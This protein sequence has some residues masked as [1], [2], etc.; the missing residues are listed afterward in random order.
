[1]VSRLA[2]CIEGFNNMILTTYQLGNQVEMKK[3]HP[4]KER[5]TLFLVVKIG[6]D[7]KIKCLGCGS[8]LMMTRDHFNSR[9]KR[10]IVSES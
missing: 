5:S 3:P 1:M 2:N 7:I 10:V 8:I 6:A 9:L 4:C